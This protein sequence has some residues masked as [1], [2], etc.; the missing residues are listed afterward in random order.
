M[1]FHISNSIKRQS[2]S[3]V[4]WY[5]LREHSVCAVLAVIFWV[6]IR[7]TL[8]VWFWVVIGNTLVVWFWIYLV[9]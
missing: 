5:I 4:V 8:A 2:V 7:H 6:V 3:E 1:L 9:W